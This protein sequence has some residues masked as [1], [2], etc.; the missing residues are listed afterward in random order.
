M[1]AVAPCPAE[2]SRVVTELARRFPGVRAWWG[3]STRE[4]WAMFRDSSG[5]DRLVEAES[6]AELCR[7]VAAVLTP[8]RF[9]RGHQPGAVRRPAGDVPPP[10]RA[11]PATE[12]RATR[13]RHELPRR[14]LLRGWR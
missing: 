2:I 14:G 7:R 9:A 10:R 8:P 13:G 6:P 12:P 4:W 1:N 5:R 3:A 11:A